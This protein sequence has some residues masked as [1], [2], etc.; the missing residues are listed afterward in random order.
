MDFSGTKRVLIYRLGSLG[1]TVVAVPALHLVARA[2]PSAKR[3]LLTNTPVH[4]K[5]PAA[6]AVL[7]GSDLVH[8]CISY[9]VGLRGVLP[10]ARLWFS[11]RRFRPQL[12]VYLTKPRGKQA[13]RRDVWF[14]RICG[15]S[16]IIG[17]PVGEFSEPLYFP[18]TGLWERESERLLRS[19]RELDDCSGGA[20]NW[21]LRLNEQEKEAARASLAPAAGAP[22]IVCAP[23]T[24]MQAKDWGRENWR[25]LLA[26]LSAAIPGAALVLVGAKE[27]APVADYA[28]SGWRGVALNLCGQLDPRETAAALDGAE[29]FLGPDSGPM[30]LAAAMGV[31]CAI[32]F[33]ARTR[34]GIWFPAGDRNRIVYH[35]TDCA[36]CDLET[37]MEQKRKCLTSITVDEMLAAALEAWNEGRKERPVSGP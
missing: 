36:D 31:P 10:L 6:W 4:T 23:G 14:F 26:R 37:C 19:I 27:D 32:A 21:D 9:P 8:S 25:Q 22:L 29:L 20:P 11:I 2:F 5:A 30:H 7:K 15:V 17:I 34:P 35:Q 13:I 33:A 16:R 3:L 12:V 24:K 18:E 1:D 28:A